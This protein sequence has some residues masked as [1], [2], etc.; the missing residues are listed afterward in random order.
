MPS[1]PSHA[2]PGPLASDQLAQ[3]ASARRRAGKIRRAV[4]TARF[5]GWTTAIFGGLTLIGGIFGLPA[6]LLGLAMVAC[7][8][9]ELRAAAHLRAL[10]PRA[11]RR[12]AWNQV[13]LCGALCAYCGWNLCNAL[14][15]GPGAAIEGL[16]AGSGAEDLLADVDAMTR[17][18][19]VMVYAAA[20]V[21]CVLVQ[22][23]TALYYASRARHLR[24]Y[25]KGTPSWVI[26]VQRAA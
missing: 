26:D 11:P 22:G 16:P 9:N 10:D 5:S 4:A 3:L 17:G 21:A 8:A 7:A 24:E 13:V 2:G 25:I 15:S 20:I 14:A 12:L 19:T 23:L 6:L 18:I 1:N